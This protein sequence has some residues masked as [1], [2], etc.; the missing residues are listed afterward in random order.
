MGM[1][2]IVYVHR[3]HLDLSVILIHFKGSIE[4]RQAITIRN[5]RIVCVCEFWI[6]VDSTQHCTVNATDN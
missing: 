4:V 3:V 5:T 1:K 2:A 6:C